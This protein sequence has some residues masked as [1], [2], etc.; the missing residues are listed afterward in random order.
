MWIRRVRSDKFE[1]DFLTRTFALIVI[2][3]PICIEFSAVTKWSQM[4]PNITK[5]NKTWVLCTMVC[6]GCVRCEKIWREFAA[7]SFALIAPDWPICI[8]FSAQ[9]KWSQMHENMKFC[10]NCTSSA[11]FA[12]S[13]VQEQTFPNAPKH[14]KM[15]QNMSLGSH[16]VFL[17]RL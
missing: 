4:H 5:C 14:Y 17:V 6:I 16:G 13:L 11:H 8:E 15:Q 3:W 12:Q 10:I 1:R 2:D 7:R 9:T